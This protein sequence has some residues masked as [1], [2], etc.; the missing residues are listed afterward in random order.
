MDPLR[1]PGRRR[2]IYTLLETAWPRLPAIIDETARLGAKWHEVSTPFVHEEDGHPIA[3]A[4]VMLVP[5]IIG[6]EAVEVGCIHAVC[7]H[8]DHRRRGHSRTVM[9]AALAYCDER[10]ATVMLNA[11]DPAVYE[12][13]GFRYL[14]QS[15]FRVTTDDLEVVESRPLR[16]LSADHPDDVAALRRLLRQ[17]TPV[18]RR[19]GITEPGWLFL[20]DVMLAREH[21]A[22]LWIAEDLD[23]IIAGKVDREQL[24]VFDVVG[25]RLPRVAEIVSRLGEPVES[26]LLYFTP[27]LLED[28][29][30]VEP[31]LVK[32]PDSLMVRGSFPIEG[33]PFCLPPFARC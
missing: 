17:R 22:P 4:G 33:T 30:P 23:L 29:A 32:T 28:A 10:V 24:H 18:S 1:D 5:M 26:V 16:P 12:R 19:L 25:P 15:A 31:L 8:P 21:F 13:Y 9:E 7:T 27:D 6:G 14:P 2:A 11:V 3:H 20:I